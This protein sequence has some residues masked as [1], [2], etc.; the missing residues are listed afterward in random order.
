MISTKRALTLAETY[1]NIIGLIKYHLMNI[2]IEKKKENANCNIVD[3]SKNRPNVKLKNETIIRYEED[4]DHFL[5]R[6]RELFDQ[7][8]DNKLE[9]TRGGICDSF[10]KFGT[11]SLNTVIKD[12]QKRTDVQ[13]KRLRQLI[14]RLKKEGE[15]YDENISYYKQFIKNGGD[16]NYFIEEGIKEWFYT[17][18]TDY[19]EYLKIYK[20][21]DRAQTKAFNEYIRKNGMDIYTERIRKAEMV[22]RLY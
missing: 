22:V 2:S 17:T 4:N 8:N 14:N 10:I 11:P 12:V 3:I 21:V 19:L 7:L 13:M 16:I 6:K 20:D 18:K 5:L 15:C 1:K 9:Y